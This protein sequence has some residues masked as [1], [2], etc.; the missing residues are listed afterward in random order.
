LIKAEFLAKANGAKT[1][2][3]NERGKFYF[4][5]ATVGNTETAEETLKARSERNYLR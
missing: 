5:K 2:L 3:G 1:W 4:K